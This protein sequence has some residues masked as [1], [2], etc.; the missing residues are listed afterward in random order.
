VR[1]IILF[2][3][4][5][6]HL[7]N[8]F[9]YLNKL[10]LEKDNTICELEKRLINLTESG[11]NINTLKYE[12]D[13]TKLVLKQYDDGQAFLQKECNRLKLDLTSCI[14]ENKLLR[15]DLDLY[16][17]SKRMLEGEKIHLKE[18]VLYKHNRDDVNISNNKH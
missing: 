12:L 7:N 9:E 10:V 14:N 13:K 18:E 8:E 17:Q 3:E 2:N 11:D 1:V 16:K 5:I 6:T 4:Y 15:Q